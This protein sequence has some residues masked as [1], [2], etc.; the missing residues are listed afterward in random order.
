MVP[1]L[2]D[3]MREAVRKNPQRPIEVEDDQTRVRYVLIARDEFHRLP[4]GLYDDSEPNPDEFLPL[5]HEALAEDWDAP[6]MELYENY[7][8]HRPKS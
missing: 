3:E 8:E 1:K 6:G 4:L 2:T 5:A 7:E